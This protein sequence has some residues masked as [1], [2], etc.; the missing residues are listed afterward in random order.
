MPF[1]LFEYL[2]RPFGLSNAAQTFQCIMDCTLDSL[3]GTFPYMGNSRV[4]SPDREKRLHRLE[5]FF[6]ALAANGLVIN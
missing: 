6:A 2:F 3:K 5:A 4:G 1:V